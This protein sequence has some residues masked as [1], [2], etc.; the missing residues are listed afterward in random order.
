[1]RKILLATTTLAML[2][3]AAFANTNAASLLYVSSVPVNTNLDQA[4]FEAI[5]WIPI[6]GVGSLGE[7]GKKTNILNYDTWTDKVIQKGKG[8]TDAGSPELEVARL[9]N[10]PGQIILLAAAA[11]GNNNNY[12]FKELRSD[13]TTANN[14]TVRYNRGVVGG[15]TWP[16]GR[17]EDFD[18]QIFTLG[19]NQEPLVINPGAGGVAPTLT[20]AP[21]I[22]GTAQVGVVLTAS[23]GTFTGDA[24]ITY[25]YQWF[26]GGVA[27]SGATASTFTP[28]TAQLGKVMTVRVLATNASGSA[29]GYSAPTSAVIAA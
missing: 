26:A 7:T 23:T 9:P 18:L 27:V 13:G 1:M 22:T 21:A 8:L 19:F 11:V 12:A 16:G 29:Q 20:V 24:T 10:D 3:A 2:S 15:P 25:Q 14:G 5:S 4:G 17:N 28:T 6:G